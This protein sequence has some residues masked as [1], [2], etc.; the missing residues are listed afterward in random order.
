MTKLKCCAV[1]YAPYAMNYVCLSCLSARITRKPQLLCVLP[2]AV[3]RFS[4]GG[5]AIR[6]VLPVFWWRHFS[7]N[8]TMVHRVAK[9]CDRHNSRDSSQIYLKDKTGST[10]HELR[11]GVKSACCKW[12]SIVLRMYVLS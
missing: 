1:F 12:V 10:Q 7:R 8:D 3:A 11:T 2:L 5:V 9:D 6:Y 4:S